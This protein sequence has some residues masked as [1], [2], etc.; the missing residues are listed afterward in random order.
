[1]QSELKYE[2]NNTYIVISGE[3]ASDPCDFRYKML[4]ANHIRN[5]LP[6]EIR[7]INNERKIYVDVTGKESVF[8]YFGTRVANRN[9]IRKLFEA[10]FVELNDVERYLINE[11]DIVLRPEMIFRN[12]HT[13]EYEFLC[14]PTEEKQGKN[15]GMISLMRFLL[16]KLDGDDEKLVDAMYGIHDMFSQGNPKFEMAYDYFAE[17]LHEEEMPEQKI[18]EEEPEDN[19]DTRAFYI[20]SVKEIGVLLLCVSGFVVMGYGLY[21]SMLPT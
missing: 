18:S 20:P 15:E 8:H 11:S 5:I 13:G 1:M 14:I 12:L 9:E 4:E 3:E 6:M 21:L 16:T 17:E 10:V 2:L 19:D 7:T